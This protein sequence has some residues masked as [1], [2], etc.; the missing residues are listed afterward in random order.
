[1]KEKI[2]KKDQLPHLFLG[3][4]E[5][6][7]IRKKVLK[8]NLKQK[9]ARFKIEYTNATY[10]TNLITVNLCRKIIECIKKDKSITYNRTLII[11]QIEDIANIISLHC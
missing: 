4:L 5:R 1:M 8:Y 3:Q 11:K 10:K 7:K 6:E 9:T 2:Y